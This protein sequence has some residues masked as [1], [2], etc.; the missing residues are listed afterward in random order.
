MPMQRRK[1]YRNKRKNKRNFDRNAK[2]TNKQNL[3]YLMR[4]GFRL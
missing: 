1:M 2:K 4:D 3:R